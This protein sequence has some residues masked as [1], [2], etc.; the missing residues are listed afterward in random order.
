MEHDGCK[1]CRYENYGAESPACTGC[2]Q[3]SIDKYSKMTN[4]DKIRAMSN[5][6]L[7]M[8]IMCPYDMSEPLPESCTFKGCI[9][10]SEEWLKKEVE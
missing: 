3:N 8:A 10:C 1:G 7:A 5:K 2:K 6:E 9:E 4:G